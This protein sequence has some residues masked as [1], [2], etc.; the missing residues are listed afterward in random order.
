MLLWK[1]S[2]LRQAL[3]LLSAEKRFLA[4]C[5]VFCD[6]NR[7]VLF[8][9]GLPL[10]RREKR[11]E[12]KKKQ[13]QSMIKDHTAIYS[14]AMILRQ[15]GVLNDQEIQTKYNRQ[16]P[17]MSWEE[18]ICI[19]RHYHL[20]PQQL[21][22]T[23]DELRE[24]ETPILVRVQRKKLCCRCSEQRRSNLSRGSVVAGGRRLCRDRSSLRY[25]AGSHG[26]C[27]AADLELFQ[28]E[29]Q[30]GVVPECNTSL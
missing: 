17:Q 21:R 19:A 20:R 8:M 14:L 22:P 1:R 25:G 24:I 4:F 12:E 29:I 6:N 10:G 2:L 26:L 5:P 11:M 16:D 7:C 3:F 28:E 18:L 13:T 23:A 30:P 15:Y 27:C 9:L